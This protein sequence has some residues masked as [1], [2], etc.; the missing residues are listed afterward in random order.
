M[1]S[2]NKKN[3]RQ[4]KNS[5]NSIKVNKKSIKNKRNKKNNNKQPIIQQNSLTNKLK[6]I[7]KILIYITKIYFYSKLFTKIKKLKQL[8]L[9]NILKIEV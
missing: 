1:P 8:V 4:N 2:S 9:K 3:L 5:F 6:S 7:K